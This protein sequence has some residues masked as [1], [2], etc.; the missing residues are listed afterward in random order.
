MSLDDIEILEDELADEVAYGN[1]QTNVERLDLV[2]QQ[3]PSLWTPTGD[4]DM[5]LHIPV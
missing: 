3:P 2:P 1:T 5:W 4:P